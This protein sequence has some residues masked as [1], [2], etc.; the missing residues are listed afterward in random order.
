M[1]ENDG[2]EERKKKTRTKKSISLKETDSA[3]RLML[4]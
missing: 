2:K 1:S 3:L 4:G